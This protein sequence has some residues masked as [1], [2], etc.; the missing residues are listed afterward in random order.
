MR[1]NHKKIELLRA[2]RCLTVKDLC[3]A[4]G[5]SYTVMAPR[6]GNDVGP[7]SAG[8]LAK[9]LGV[10]VEEIIIWED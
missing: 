3:K 10:D 4:A 6:T 1:L 9:A 2:K 7:I 5:V 8:K